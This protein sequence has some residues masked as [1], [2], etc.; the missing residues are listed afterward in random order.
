MVYVQADDGLTD[1]VQ[2][3]VDAAPDVVP[4][5]VPV[6]AHTHYEAVEV[7]EHVEP[8]V[9][10]AKHVVGD[11]VDEADA[12]VVRHY[13][14]AHDKTGLN[15]DD[16]QAFSHHPHAHPVINREQI[17]EFPATS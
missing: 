4:D 5:D 13:A 12:V 7:L 3:Y 9:H 6:V 15:A 10:T 2:H 17:S 16:R 14:A 8:T 1:V 11:K